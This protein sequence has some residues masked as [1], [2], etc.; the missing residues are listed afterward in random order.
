MI[1]RRIYDF[2][3]GRRLT[4]ITKSLNIFIAIFLV[5]TCVCGVLYMR[6]YTYKSFDMFQPSFYVT[7]PSNVLHCN[8]PSRNTVAN[9]VTK[10]PT[11]LYFPLNESW[12]VGLSE[13]SYTKSWYTI[14]RTQ[15]IQLCEYG[16][17]M[18]VIVFKNYPGGGTK[19]SVEPGKNNGLHTVVHFFIS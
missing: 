14:Q 6:I 17:E 15:H 8:D 4:K 12:E 5:T 3:R 7:L 1:L 9:F 13:I 11:R 2:A 10:L 18:A 19:A 16:P